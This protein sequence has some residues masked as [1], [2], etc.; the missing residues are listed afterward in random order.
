MRLRGAAWIALLA[1]VGCD[2]SIAGGLDEEQA[3]EVVLALDGQGISGL[4]R[5][6]EG[7]SETPTFRVEV[8]GEDVGRS[9]NVLRANGLPRHAER[10]IEEVFGAGGLVP[11]A[12]EES[13][14]YT[15]ALCGELARSLETMDGILDARVHIALPAARDLP[16]DAVPPSPRASVLLTYRASA[17][18]PYA[19][20]AVRALVAG[21]VQG[22]APTDVAVIGVPAPAAPTSAQ[23][24]LVRLGPIAV[25]RGSAGA[26]KLLF[27]SS[28]ALNVLIALGAAVLVLRRKKPPDAPSDGDDKPAGG[29]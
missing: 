23:T 14:R 1:L 27:G 28:I 16:L 9:L 6:E 10:G 15:S 26:L 24:A 29:R 5:R 3:N 20:D 2:A 22:M 18:R 19:D 11:T 21:A 25:T 13:A 17:V 7:T 4:K 12:T 8:S